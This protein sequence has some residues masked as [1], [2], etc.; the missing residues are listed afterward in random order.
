MRALQEEFSMKMGVPVFIKPVTEK[1][2]KI[3]I[4][5]HSLDDFDLIADFFGVEKQ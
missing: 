1:S 2:G 5:Y 4:H 3:E